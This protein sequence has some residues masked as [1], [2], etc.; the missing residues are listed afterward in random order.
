[1]ST[2]TY[3]CAHCDWGV[4]DVDGGACLAC[5]RRHPEPPARTWERRDVGAFARWKADGLG[6]ITATSSGLI[7][8]FYGHTWRVADTRDELERVLTLLVERLPGP[9]YRASWAALR[10]A[11]ASVEGFRKAA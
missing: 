2:S 6:T 9:D 1:M 3:T 5:R 11:W 7:I 8:Q 10:E 4:S